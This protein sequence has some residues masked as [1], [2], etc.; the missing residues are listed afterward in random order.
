[1][2]MDRKKYGILMILK[3]KVILLNQLVSFS[4]TFQEHNTPY[5]YHMF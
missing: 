2:L 5:I 4:V 1:M 3:L